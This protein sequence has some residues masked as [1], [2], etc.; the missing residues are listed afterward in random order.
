[1][2]VL[3]LGAI[4][5]I[6]FFS[7]AIAQDP[8]HEFHQDSRNWLLERELYANCKRYAESVYV[9]MLMGFNMTHPEAQNKEATAFEYMKE[10]FL[11]CYK[12]YKPT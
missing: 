7:A 11:D 12:P 6:L 5:L 3:K 10:A 8:V 2:N 4:V 9:D 1:V